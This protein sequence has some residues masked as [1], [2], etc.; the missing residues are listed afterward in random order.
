MIRILSVFVLVMVLFAGCKYDEG[1]VLSF[2]S[3]KERVV[4]IWTFGKVTEAD[5]TDITANYDG[6]F[7][8]LDQEG[9]LLIH[10]MF[11]GNPQDEYGTWVFADRK[12]SI[13]LEYS[14]SLVQEA[15]PKQFRILRLKEKNMKV[16]SNANITYDLTA[17]L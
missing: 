1:P 5:G 3:K 15:F 11:G 14:N 16:K 10:W 8:S 13:H 17:T 2:R 9:G 4:N 6:W 12:E 7:V